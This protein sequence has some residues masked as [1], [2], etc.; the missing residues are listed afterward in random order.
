MRGAIGEV[1]L[2]KAVLIHQETQ[3]LAGFGI[4]DREMLVFIGLDLVGQEVQHFGQRMFF[5]IADFVQQ[6]SAAGGTRNHPFACLISAGEGSF[7]VTE[8]RIRKVCI[9]QAGY[10]DADKFATDA[11][12]VVHRTCH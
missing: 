7:L 8:K 1:F 4:G 11:A 5:V 12:Q 2:L 6:E 10:V 9:I 3:H